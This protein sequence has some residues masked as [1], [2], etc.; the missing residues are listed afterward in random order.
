M[1]YIYV[2]NSLR[3]A[4]VFLTFRGFSGWSDREPDI[5]IRI[6]PLKTD[7]RLREQVKIWRKDL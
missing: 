2:W 4:E 7:I 1:V 5:Q 3:G 6:P